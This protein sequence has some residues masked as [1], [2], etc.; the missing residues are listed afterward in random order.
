L[1]SRRRHSCR[2]STAGA[3]FGVVS[4]RVAFLLAAINLLDQLYGAASPSVLAGFTQ[5]AL[6]TAV[7]LLGLGMA[8]AGAGRGETMLTRLRAA[9]PAGILTRNMVAAA[10]VIPV[11]VGW[12]RLTGERLGWYGSAYGVGLTQLT[13]MVLLL[14]AVNHVGGVLERSEASRRLAEGE[15]ERAR[16]E[17]ENANRAK[18][19]F[20]VP[21][22][23]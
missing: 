12:L 22:E 18:S 3:R 19:E 15:R 16:E 9:G 5:M 17:A 8:V 11:L 4:S 10:L 1:L 21:N 7:G 6:P 2:P 23:P 20:P 14:W 13:A